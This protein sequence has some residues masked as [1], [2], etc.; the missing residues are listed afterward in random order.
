MRSV[1]LLLFQFQFKTLQFFQKLKKT[2]EQG[3]TILQLTEFSAKL[4]TEN[5]RNFKSKRPVSGVNSLL[6]LKEMPEDFKTATLAVLSKTEVFWMRYNSV[7]VD[8]LRLEEE[9]IELRRENAKLKAQ[10]RE[11][12]SDLNV[13]N[14][15][16]TSASERLRPHSMKVEKVTRSASQNRAM[17]RPVTSIEGNL[18]V[19]VRSRRI[20]S[21]QGKASNIYSALP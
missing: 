20:V 1:A 13:S 15:R 6:G 2:L 4:E 17:R 11:Y 14:G 3:T 12:L 21:S 8:S 19:A 7:R 10:L 18:S 5:E 9:R 16:V